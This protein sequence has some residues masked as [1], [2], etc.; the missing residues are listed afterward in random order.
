MNK[1]IKVTNRVYGEDIELLANEEDF[2]I[3]M[4]TIYM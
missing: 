2:L 4:K 1:I 3:C